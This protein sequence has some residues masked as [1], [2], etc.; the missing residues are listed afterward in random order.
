MPT[1]ISDH[2]PT[3]RRRRVEQPP[4]ETAS[5]P[6]PAQAIPPH[7][8]ARRAYELFITGGAE[9]GHDVEHWLEAERDLRRMRS[10]ES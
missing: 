6:A 7:E 5:A 10:S 1:P 2:S 9:H 8:I 3:A 4:V